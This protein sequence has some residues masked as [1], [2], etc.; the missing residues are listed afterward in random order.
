M[1]SKADDWRVKED[2]ES[3]LAQRKH[4]RDLS[5]DQANAFDK[6]ISLLATGALGLSAVFVNGLIS[7]DLPIDGAWLLLDGFVLSLRC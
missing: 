6:A 2:R 3:Y 1:Y 4:L 7:K 5:V